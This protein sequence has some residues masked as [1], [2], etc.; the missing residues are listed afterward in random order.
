[1]LGEEI[2]EARMIEQ[3]LVSFPEKFEAKISWQFKSSPIPCKLWSRGKHTQIDLEM[4]VEE[5]LWPI[6][7]GKAMLLET[8][9]NSNTTRRKEKK[10][11]TT[12]RNLEKKNFLNA[13]IIRNLVVQTN[14]TGLGRHIIQIMQRI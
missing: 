3:G 14:I 2:T 11:M 6:N 9:G 1:M 8:Q 12:S 10:V 13:V 4:V 7:E 5:H